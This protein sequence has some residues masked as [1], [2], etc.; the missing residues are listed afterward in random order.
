MTDDIRGRHV[1]GPATVDVDRQ[2]H[3]VHMALV[4][5]GA[6]RLRHHDGGLVPL[7]HS[8]LLIEPTHAT[9]EVLEDARLG[10]VSFLSVASGPGL[11]EVTPGL[12]QIAPV[13]PALT[14][15]TEVVSAWVLAEPPT[16]TFARH[17][18]ERTI[19]D[20]VGGVILDSRLRP[21]SGREQSLYSAALHHIAD[22]YADPHLGP[23][24]IAAA[25]N[26]STRHLA[27]AFHDEAT[28]VTASIAS[29]RVNVAAALI[30]QQPELGLA[31]V[32]AKSG[33]PSLQ[34]MRR[35]FR[36]GERPSPSAVRTL[37]ARRHQAANRS[38]REPDGAGDDQ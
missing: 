23:E 32:S 13:D 36:A 38:R 7:P 16:G 24:S 34:A 27:R 9:I 3:P 25:F 30:S 11:L 21:T 5:E 29:I 22:H 19:R 20:L 2:R 14:R 6:C 12:R 26:V 37:A 8:T 33:F 28:T 18:I 31:E 1:A 17:I 15:I 10:L 4:L 35:A